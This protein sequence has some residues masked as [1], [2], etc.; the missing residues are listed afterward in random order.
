MTV[1]VTGAAGH[2]GGNLV[3]ALLAQGRTVRA[4]VREDRRALE[5]LDVE[6]AS[7]DVRDR[8]GL[9]VAFEGAEVVYHLAAQ[10]SIV[11][12]MGGL[13]EDVNVQG[14]KNVVDACLECGVKRLV[15]VSSI[16]AYHQ[17]RRY[18]PIEE[19]GQLSLSLNECAYDRSKARGQLQ[20]LA[21]VE[22]GLDAVILNP[23]AVIGPHDYKPSRMG[24]TF[25]E[26]A[27]GNFPSLVEGGFDWVDVRDFC[28]AAL[29]AEKKGRCGENYLIS[30]TY[31]TV[32]R[33][34]EMISEISGSKVPWFTCP[35]WLARCAAPFAHGFAA[36]LRKEPLF[37]S[38]SLQALRANTQISHEK[39]AREL[40]YNPRPLEETLCD[41]YDWWVSQG[42]LQPRSLS[43]VEESVAHA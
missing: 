22:R 43:E 36:L 12:G 25:L 10:I 1:V 14:V 5:G 38:E 26:M 6:I 13:V 35:Q 8:A 4:L 19:S 28:D 32:R 3:R 24:K 39:A 33:L 2:V 20:V 42:L 30:G 11:G 7:V 27:R 41:I 16:H 21:G 23:T 31:T 15:H 29:V 18:E 40:G 37:T 17:D 34:H 9:G